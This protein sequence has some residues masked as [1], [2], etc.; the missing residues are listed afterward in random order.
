MLIIVVLI[1]IIV[2]LGCGWFSLPLLWQITQITFSWSRKKWDAFLCCFMSTIAVVPFPRPSTSHKALYMEIYETKCWWKPYN[3]LQSWSVNA[4]KHNC[5]SV[6]S[7]SKYWKDI[8]DGQVH[9]W[10]WGSEWGF[11]ENISL[12]V[13]HQ[14]A[15][16]WFW[17]K[18][19]RPLGIKSLWLC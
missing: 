3:A 16:T 4:D 8:K 5:L 17:V 7:S 18:S 2:V 11:Y 1:I 9:W 10:N 13:S 6:L 14:F 19:M 12:L 15:S